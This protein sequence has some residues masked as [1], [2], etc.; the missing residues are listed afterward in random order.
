MQI[1]AINNQNFGRNIKPKNIQNVQK[2]VTKNMESGLNGYGESKAATL[3]TGISSAIGIAGFAI[4]CLFNHGQHKADA[5]LKPVI[6][7][8]DSTMVDKIAA[9][10]TAVFTDTMKVLSK[11][12]K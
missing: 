9:N 11:I 2:A 7:N 6:E 4:M 3:I 12:K 8:I 5:P 1:Q 10:D